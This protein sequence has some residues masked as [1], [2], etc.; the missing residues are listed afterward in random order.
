MAASNR[1]NSAESRRRIAV[2]AARLIAEQGLRDYHSAKLKAAQLLGLGEATAL[3]RNA[4]IE[5]ALRE[6]QRLFQ[7]ST[8]PGNLA[9]LR[10]VAVEA[11]RF[12]DSFQPR[13]V[14]AVLEGTADEYSAVC[15]HVF[16]EQPERV[17]GFLDE[18]GIPF[19]LQDRRLR[20]S[21]SV[22][23]EFPALL[24]SA[25]GTTIDLTVFSLDGLRQAPLDRISER[26][27]QR[28]NLSRVL[29]LLNSQESS[30]AILFG[31]MQQKLRG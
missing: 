3:P 4:E 26:S 13:L 6:H 11:M 14:G 5:A 12:L 10:N 27:M 21:G 29:D 18:H 9:R 1:G 20:F 7:A 8:Q 19:E 30:V 2:E 28:A 15:L 23:E 22:E 24:F 31:T 25:G 16:V 17:I